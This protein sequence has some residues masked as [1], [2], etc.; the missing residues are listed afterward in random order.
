VIPHEEKF[1]TQQDA[2]ELFEFIKTQPFVRPPN[3]R[4]KTC[5]LKRLSFPGYSPPL[6]GDRT[7][8]RPSNYD[9]SRPVAEAP[10]LYRKFAEKLS[11]FAGKEIN[12]L[13]TIG[14][15]PDDHMDF[16]QHEEDKKR[17]DQTVWVLS[18]GAVHPVAV[19][20]KGVKDK[21]QWEIIYPKHGSL[22]V[23]PSE[24]NLTHE[25]AV[26][27]GDDWSHNGLRLAVNTKHIPPP[28][29]KRK[30][31]VCGNDAVPDFVVESGGDPT[32]CY[33]HG[34]NI[35]GP[36]SGTDVPPKV[37]MAMEWLRAY[38]ADGDQPISWGRGISAGHSRFNTVG[39]YTR[40]SNLG[41]P[42]EGVGAAS[43]ADA[44]R[45]LGITEVKSGPRG[46]KR[47]HLP[48][49]NPQK[50]VAWTHPTLGLKVWCKRKGCETPPAGAVLVD[51]STAFGNQNYLGDEASFRVYAEKILA[52]GRVSLD[53]L[54]GKD[55][56]CWCDPRET[57]CH[58]RVW[59]DLANREKP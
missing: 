50:P 39:P 33:T 27:Y 47:W 43:I 49:E 56:V 52:S 34:G 42:P 46:G 40:S 1:Y 29:P 26:L 15:L 54:H 21:S 31:E 4:N 36:N 37:R 7:F 8:K 24:Y 9:V 58:A 12:Y 55:L 25:H 23:L 19:R 30:C 45:L 22:Y 6:T 28:P 5:R 57:W 13:S 35:W 41:V 14:Y 38:L 32:K 17:E 2:D 51:R 18:L 48:T 20:P 16:H 3:P 53:G 59:M 44:V 11:A 10:P